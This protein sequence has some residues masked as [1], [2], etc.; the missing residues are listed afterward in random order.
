MTLRRIVLSFMAAVLTLSLAA[1]LQ[2]LRAKAIDE[3]QLKAVFL[4]RLSL[5]VTWPQ[6]AFHNADAPFTIGILGDDPFGPHLDRVVADEQV[7]GR[8]IKIERYQSE[9]ELSERPCQILFISQSF[10]QQWSR[11]KAFLGRFNLL[12]V[13]DMPGFGQKGGMVSINKHRNR[14]KIEINLAESRKSE[15]MI[16]A[17]L[18][19]V[20]RQVQTDAAGKRP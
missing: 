2:P 6:E 10:S 14:I 12:T 4:Y 13:S 3:Y 1:T 9:G 8:S 16:S 15:L 19:K 11:I 17:K 7:G 20:A 5:F 18:L